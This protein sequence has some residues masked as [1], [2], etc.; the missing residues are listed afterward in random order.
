[1][2]KGA[3]MKSWLLVLLCVLSFTNHGGAANL[4]DL[5]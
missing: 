4:E 3:N 1:M 5:D 2:R